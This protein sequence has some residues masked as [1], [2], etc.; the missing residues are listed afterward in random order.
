MSRIFFILFV[1]PFLYGPE[2][3]TELVRRTLVLIDCEQ[4][5]MAVVAFA[6]NEYNIWSNKWSW[7]TYTVHILNRITLLS[8]FLSVIFLPISKK[9]FQLYIQF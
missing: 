3:G 5:N 9:R 7:K 2:I 4:A 8:D 1:V 6:S